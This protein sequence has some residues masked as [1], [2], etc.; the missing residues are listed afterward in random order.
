MD[1]DQT[2]HLGGG[3]KYPQDKPFW[4][5]LPKGLQPSEGRQTRHGG[6][7]ASHM[8]KYTSQ[9]E[10]SASDL[11]EASE[12]IYKS[13]MVYQASGAFLFKPIKL[14]WKSC[15]LRQRNG[16]K[17]AAIHSTGGRHVVGPEGCAF[18]VRRGGWYIP[19]SVDPHHHSHTRG[20]LREQKIQAPSLHA[21]ATESGGTATQSPLSLLYSGLLPSTGAISKPAAHSGYIATNSLDVRRS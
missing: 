16:G 21:S 11:C 20:Q 4:R 3:A 2:P 7:E 8:G 12:A 14:G 15:G 18:C 1:P 10:T 5:I 9:R 19:T 6:V 17:H 13:H